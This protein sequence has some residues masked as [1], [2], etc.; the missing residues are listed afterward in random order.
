MVTAKIERMDFLV[1]KECGDS[2]SIADKL[3]AL[4]ILA[5]GIEKCSL[6]PDKSSAT[7]GGPGNTLR[8]QSVGVREARSST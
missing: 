3:L 7:D 6:E 5:R 4:E 1:M 2:G 8:A